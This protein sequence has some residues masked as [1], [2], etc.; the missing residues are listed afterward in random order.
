MFC[1]KCIEY[2]KKSEAKNFIQSLNAKLSILRIN[3]KGKVK[4]KSYK[5]RSLF[6]N[7]VSPGDPI[8]LVL[9]ELIELNLET[10]EELQKYFDLSKRINS[11]LSTESHRSSIR[12]AEKLAKIAEKN[13]RPES[14]DNALAAQDQVEKI[15]QEDFMGTDFKS[16]ISIIRLI[17]DM[18]EISIIL[19]KRVDAYNTLNPKSPIPN[20]NPLAFL[21]M[22]EV[23]RIFRAEGKQFD[24]DSAEAA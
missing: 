5:Y 22:S 1:F 17:K 19:N 21:S 14:P 3:L 2:K 7:G 8:D 10:G 18:V 15:G 12:S 23:N 16:E 4:K 9:N 11:L 20:V 24:V 6:K 13:E